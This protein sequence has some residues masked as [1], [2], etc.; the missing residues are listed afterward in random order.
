MCKAVDRSSDNWRA[1]SL[2]SELLS[3]SQGVLSKVLVGPCISAGAN[4]QEYK[5]L[6]LS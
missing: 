5:R 2:V 4:Q 3:F 1:F 6:L